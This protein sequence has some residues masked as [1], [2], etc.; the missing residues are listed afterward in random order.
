MTFVRTFFYLIKKFPLPLGW[1][2]KIACFFQSKF[3]VGV[4]CVVLNSKKEVL[5]FY[6]TYLKN[7]WALPGGYM[8]PN[9]QP[10]ETI[11]RE[12]FEESKLAVK[13]LQFLSIVTDKYVSRIKIFY[14]TTFCQGTFSASTEVLKSQYFNINAL[15]NLPPGQIEEIRKVI[16]S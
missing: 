16:G 9:E 8:K 10:E 1:K 6:H 13:K 15:P 2:T 12:I 11:T 4:N 14:T 7:S 5:L 3:A